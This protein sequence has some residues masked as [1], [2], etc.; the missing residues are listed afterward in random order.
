MTNTV[1][2]LAAK[3]PDL[4]LFDVFDERFSRYGRV[5]ELGDTSALHQAM[6]KIAIPES[7]N[8]YVADDVSLKALDIVS[9][10]K[11]SV[12]RDVPIEAG[13]CNGHSFALNAE[14]YHRCSEVNFTT[15]GLVLLLA[16]PEDIKGGKLDSKRVVGVYLPPD[17]PVEIYPR[18]LHFA[19]CRLSNAGFNCLVILT[20]GTNTALDSVDSSLPGEDGMLWMRNKWLICHP[21]SPQAAKGAYIGI[22]GENITLKI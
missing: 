8:C 19:P 12:Y 10:I 13:Y 9:K 21:D 22:T 5:L 18:V 3:N 11:L 2:L 15:T 7:G 17:V 20:D 1:E 14:E 6:L 4:T 16:L